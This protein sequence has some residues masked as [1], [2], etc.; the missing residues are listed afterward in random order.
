MKQT[1]CEFMLPAVEYLGHCITAQ[2]L[3]PTDD[4]IQ[5]IR[6]APTPTNVSQLKSFLGLVNYY[7][8][9]L[10]NLSSVL[11]PLYSLLQQKQSWTWDSSQESAFQKAKTSLTSDS[12]LVHYDPTKEL[13]LACD[14]S[15]YGVG[16]VLSHRMEDGTDKPIAFASRSLAPT[17]QKYSQLDK[18]GLSIIF[19]VK[20]YH[21]HLYGRHFTILSDH[22]PLQHLF[23]ETSATAEDNSTPT[24]VPIRRSTR[25]SVPPARYDPSST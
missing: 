8:K 7:G 25:V 2:G 12:L 16:A 22:K 1:K 3:K 20:R 11:A 15:P 5:A 10:P 18:E 14:A 19:G 24:T 17:E 13:L 23:S 9:F 4:K 21:Q 6:E